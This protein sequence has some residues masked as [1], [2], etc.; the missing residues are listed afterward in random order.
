MINVCFKVYDKS[1]WFRSRKL[2]INKIKSDPANFLVIILPPYKSN[3]FNL[4]LGYHIQSKFA[5]MYFF[6]I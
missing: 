5:I 4:I 2:A 1:I 3:C 6:S